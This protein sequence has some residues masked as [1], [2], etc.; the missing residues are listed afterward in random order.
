M[1]FSVLLSQQLGLFQLVAAFV[2]LVAIVAV[3]GA[4]ATLFIVAVSNRTDA[5]PTGSRPMGAYLFSAA[6]LLL[7]V[8]YLGID[9]ALNSLINLLG[10]NPSPFPGFPGP[11]TRDDALRACVLGALLVVV[12]GGAMLLHLRRGIALAEAEGNPS[13]PTK[14]VM[15]TYVALVSFA[16]ILIL[17]FAL[18]ATGWLVAGLISP[19]VFVGNASRTVITR[20]L[21]D[22]LVLVLLAGSIFSYHQR[23]APEGLRLLSNISPARHTHLESPPPTGA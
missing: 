13:G 5:D 10:T 9:V 23:Y 4:F 15:R 17:V 19:S 14:K 22:A 20:S 1:P 11:S 8:A 3:L 18:V 2:E 21:L 16:S 12:A 7:W 6:F